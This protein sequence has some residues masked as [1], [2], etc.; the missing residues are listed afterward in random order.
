MLTY[1]YDGLEGFRKE[2]SRQRT[3]FFCMGILGFIGGNEMSGVTSFC[4]F[5]L[6]D[7]RRYASLA[8]GIG[9]FAN[10]KY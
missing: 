1:L 4:R 10:L 9:T 7:D 5:W 3:W 6:M 8:L 2:F